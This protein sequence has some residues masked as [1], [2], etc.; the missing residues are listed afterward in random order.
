ME[1]LAKQPEVELTWW[2]IGYED[3][4][5]EKTLRENLKGKQF[6]FIFVSK[7]LQF[8][9]WEELNTPVV[10]D[11]NE[12]IERPNKPETALQ[13]LISI[14]PSIVIARL[15]HEMKMFQMMFPQIHWVHIPHSA[16]ENIFKDYGLPKIYD[17]TLTGVLQ[18]EYY[19]FRQRLHSLLPEL[20]KLG[21]KAEYG[22]FGKDLEAADRDQHLVDMA[23]YINQSKICM[24]CSSFMEERLAKFV[25]IP[26]AGSVLACDPP[27]GYGDVMPPCIAIEPWMTDKEIIDTLLSYLKQPMKLADMQ[28]ASLEWAKEY[29]MDKYAKKV[30]QVL[31]NYQAKQHLS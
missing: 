11:Y 31:K 18:P 20:Q 8:K 23:K 3:F 2:G 12:M 7:P 17:I 28:K 4:D 24:T 26:A 16:N 22:F 5:Q 25:E 6:D 30:L 9:G 15:K 29:T 1:F 19:P 13:E 10:M 21:L 14:K 27:F